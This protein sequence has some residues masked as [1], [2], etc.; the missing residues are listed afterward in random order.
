MESRLLLNL[1]VKP[2]ERPMYLF[3]Y[4]KQPEGGKSIYIKPSFQRCE[5]S[6]LRTRITQQ[7]TV[8]LGIHRYGYRNIKSYLTSENRVSQGAGTQQK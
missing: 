5:S 3:M 6:F 2:G 8:Y 1:I 4:W 7:V